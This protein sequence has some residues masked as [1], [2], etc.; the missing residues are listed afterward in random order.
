MAAMRASTI[1]ALEGSVTRPER[2]AYVDCAWSRDA[3]EARNGR[4]MA[5]IRRTMGDLRISTH[6]FRALAQ[7]VRSVVA[8][9]SWKSPVRASGDVDPTRMHQTAT[10]P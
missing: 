10:H 7:L 5:A 9:I 3:D 2:E 1:A 8:G 4:A 6:P